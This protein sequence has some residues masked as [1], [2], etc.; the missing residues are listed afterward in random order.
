MEALSRITPATVDVLRVL[1]DAGPVVWGLRVVK[2]TGRP[3]GS[4]YPILERLERAGWAESSWEEDPERSGPRRR[5]YAL[6]GDGAE[7]ARAVV[8]NAAVRAAGRAAARTANR[9]SAA[10]RPASRPAPGHGVAREARA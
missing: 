5:L 4:V 2:E 7:A 3:S 9:A 6:T 1:L 8:E 10:P